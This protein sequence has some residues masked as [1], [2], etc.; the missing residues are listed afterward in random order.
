MA[1]YCLA[2][3]Q[4]QSV[5]FRLRGESMPPP[6]FILG[7]DRSG[8]HWLGRILDAHPDVEVTF[9]KQPVFG[10]VF[11]MAID[12]E[13][14]EQ[15]FPKLLRRYR[16]EQALVAPKI[17]VDKSHPNIWHAEKLAEAIPGARFI[18]IHRNVYAT[19]ASMLNHPGVEWLAKRWP[20]FPV[21]NRFFG[22]SDAMAAE[23]DLMPPAAK[24]AARWRAHHD[25]LQRLSGVMGSRLSVIS[26][27]SLQLST[28][29]EV[30]RLEEFLELR[31]PLPMPEVRTDSLNRWE[32]ELDPAMVRQIQSVLDS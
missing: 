4:G 26:Y 18:G 3:T 15:L 2:Y 27:E 16:Y 9:E 5:Q 25:E 20:E 31:N 13:M 8:T 29:D 11:Q 19:V 21:P 28:A 14:E 6:V 17:Y 10:W 24:C 7:S 1:G 23:Y 12:P 32:S 22:V 30:S